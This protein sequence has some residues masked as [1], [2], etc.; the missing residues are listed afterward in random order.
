MST[1]I[2]I[3]FA[4]I[5]ERANFGRLFA[6]SSSSKTLTNNFCLMN[7]PWN[8]MNIPYN[9]DIRIIR[10]HCPTSRIL[11]KQTKNKRTTYTEWR[12]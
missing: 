2:I 3:H 11:I 1:Q 4:N 7:I 5:F 8:L 6:N 12:N 9:K 10:K